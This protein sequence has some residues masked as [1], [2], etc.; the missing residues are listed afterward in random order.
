MLSECLLSLRLPLVCCSPYFVTGTSGSV[1]YVRPV[2]E[3]LA[4]KPDTL[5]KRILLQVCN[6]TESDN[7]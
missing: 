7:T 4:P 3:R 5:V 6:F 2:F 1:P